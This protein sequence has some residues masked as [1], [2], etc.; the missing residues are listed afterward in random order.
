[1][2]LVENIPVITKSILSFSHNRYPSR[3]EADRLSI[4]KAQREIAEGKKGISHLILRAADDDIDRLKFLF[5]IH[6][7]P[8]MCYSLA[9]LLHSELREIVVV[10]S[11]E[12]ETVLNH[13]L[14]AVGTQN[15]KV[16]FIAEDTDNLCLGNTMALGRGELSLAPNE[17]ILFQPGDLPFMWDLDHILFDED[18]KH[19]NLILW[20]NS[21]QKM[22]PD[23]LENP[24][25]EFVQ[26]N[27]HYRV[28]SE[29]ENELHDIKEPNIY[30]INLSAV[31]SDI[32]EQSHST[33]KDGQILK[34]GVRE[35]LAT[36]VRL[37][38]LLPVLA[39][40]LVNFRS[41]LKR[42]READ[43]YQ[44]GMHSH[45]FQRGVSILLDTGLATKFNGDPAY[46][47]DVDALEDWEDFESLA[48]YA[49]ETHGKEGLSHIYPYGDELLDFRDRVMPQLKS[50]IPMFRDF[51][52]YLNRIYQTL[53]MGYAPFDSGG[54][55]RIPGKNIPKVE[56]A[57]F[58][59][60]RKCEELKVK[61]QEK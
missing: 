50:E 37:I 34:A 48:Q 9:N 44:F 54:G 4:A 25:S 52:D 22:F 12:V 45:N 41:D 49:H 39:Y 47:S 53:Q 46:V 42:F 10:G 27:Y 24:D 28:I 16:T 38:R 35:A 61:S 2:S 8:L 58:W 3:K 60:S 31:P 19:N 13:F 7:I 15:K 55:Y 59:Y 26:R 36:P 6:G 1:M 43:R 32:I 20:L 23:F 40:H 11:R 57:Y 21:R 30:P 51:P 17:L 33:R 29:T 18:I 56:H 14:D 5:P